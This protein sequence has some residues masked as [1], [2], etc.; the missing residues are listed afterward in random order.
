MTANGARASKISKKIIRALEIS[1]MA[2][3]RAMAL[4]DLRGRF[5]PA[6]LSEP[7]RQQWSQLVRDHARAFSQSTRQLR[8]ELSPVFPRSKPRSSD[9]A[10]TI[11]STA[12]VI[13]EL[14]RLAKHDDEAIRAAFTL[15]S[16]VA[17]PEVLDTSFWR[18]LQESER[19]AAELSTSLR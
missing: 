1:Q 14:F 3:L 6:Q 13:D 11:D 5:N 17:P 4:H 12:S 15:S 18:D 7:A 19:L 9:A 16:S 10:S 8:E 2:L